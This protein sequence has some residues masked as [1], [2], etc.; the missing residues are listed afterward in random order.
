MSKP[1][2]RRLGV[3]MRVSE[4]EIHGEVRDALARDWAGFLAAALPGW[5]WLPIPNLGAAAAVY[6]QAWQLDALIF[7]GGGDV[8]RDARRDD[9]EAALL[10]W[11][12][13][14]NLPVFGVCRG[15][16][17]IQVAL[18][19]SL[20]PCEHHVGRRHPV[21]LLALPELDVEPS[22]EE[23]N[24]VHRF[25]IRCEAL[26]EGLQPFAVTADGWVEG[27]TAVQGRLAGVMWHPERE[28]PSQQRDVRI[29]R[30]LFES[31]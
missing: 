20:A 16:Q 10:G 21:R 5:Q 1:V 14:C 4:D 17:A 24:S 9:T 8:G 6:A 27:A 26:A 12:R 11:A 25:G 19:G 18:G 15:F 3:T 29:L 28:Q 22:L 7:S 23:V 2:L 31:F 30:R 13:R